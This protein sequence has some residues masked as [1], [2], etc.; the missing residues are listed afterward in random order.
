MWQNLWIC[1][2]HSAHTNK[3]HHVWGN[4]EELWG[5]KVKETVVFLSKS[6]SHLRDGRHNQIANLRG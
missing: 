5:L 4:V 6:F 3:I 1:Y 2:I